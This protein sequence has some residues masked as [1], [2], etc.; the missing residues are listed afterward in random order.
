MYSSRTWCFSTVLVFG[1]DFDNLYKYWGVKMVSNEP[2][3]WLA[4]WL[5]HVTFIEHLHDFYVGAVG[6]FREQL[7][8]PQAVWRDDSRLHLNAPA[9]SVVV[10]ADR[11][12]TCHQK[13]LVM[14]HRKE[15][16]IMCHNMEM[17]SSVSRLLVIVML[18]Y[19]FSSCWNPV[20]L[21]QYAVFTS[22]SQGNKNL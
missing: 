9:V 6:P 10:S 4:V 22:I 11:W 17:T 3:S 16:S 5:L 20:S 12:H 8:A 1:K 21:A 13:T 7:D 2:K 18:K 14:F 19:Q 15:C